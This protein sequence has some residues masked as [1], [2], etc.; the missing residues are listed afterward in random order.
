MLFF[1]M[2]VVVFLVERASGEA[3]YEGACDRR[4]ALFPVSI[5][6]DGG[7]LFGVF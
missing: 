5:G 6:V 7:S 1:E 4:Q 3:A 2:P